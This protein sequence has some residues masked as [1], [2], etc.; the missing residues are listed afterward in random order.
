[1]SNQ[2]SLPQE[3]LNF[4]V[5]KHSKKKLGSQYQEHGAGNIKNCH[6]FNNILCRFLFCVAN[7]KE[8]HEGESVA[9]NG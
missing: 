6:H 3:T 8:E 7:L 4:R 1:L 9:V 2:F 5:L